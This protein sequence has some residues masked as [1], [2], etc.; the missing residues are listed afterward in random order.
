MVNVIFVVPYA[1]E[2]TMRFVRAMANLPGVNLGIL[3][4]EPGER[5]SEELGTRLGCYHYVRNPLDAND[6]AEGVHA[7]ASNWGG[8]VDR[9]VG[10]LEQL[11]EPLAAVR[12]HYH[13]HGMSLDEA[14]NFRDKARMK[15]V[16]REAG[17]PCARH[18]LAHSAEEALGFA[19]ECLPL[20]AKPPDGAGARNTMRIETKAD[21]E[22][23]LRTVPPSEYAPLMLEEF[24]QGKEHSFD[25]VSV[26]GE[27]VFHSISSYTPTPLDV[28]ENP[29]IQWCVLL[30]REIEGDEFQD[31]REAGPRAL[32]AL[33][34]RTGLTHMEWFRRPDGSMA[35]SEVAG[36]YT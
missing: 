21:L 7:I 18:R 4:Q 14:R 25:S 36:S 12:E 29:W 5:F 2:T 9:L 31:I 20:V 13:I 23:Y 19:D 26:H 33:G 22:G 35:I 8:R 3:S 17:L 1:M 16:L 10:V 24:I 6:L 11:Q 34:M 28:M 32:D 27:H 15:D 30:P